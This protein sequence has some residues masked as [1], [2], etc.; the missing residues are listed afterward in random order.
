MLNAFGQETMA[1]MGVKKATDEVRTMERAEAIKLLQIHERA[2]QG[3]LRAKLMRDIRQDLNMQSIIS[4]NKL[5]CL[6]NDMLPRAAVQE[7]GEG[8]R[9]GRGEGGGGGGRSVPVQRRPP[10]TEAVARPPHPQAGPAQT[11]GRTHLHWNGKL[12]L[13][14]QPSR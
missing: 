14:Y 9:E 4:I 7:D 12:C 13:N 6:L 1:K 3:R 2:R 5:H 10:H 8:E 11:G